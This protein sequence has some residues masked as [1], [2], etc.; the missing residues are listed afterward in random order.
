VRCTLDWDFVSY[1]RCSDSPEE[2][3]SVPRISEIIFIS[4]S[5]F[6]IDCEEVGCTSYGPTKNNRDSN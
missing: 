1:E 3:V 6:E 4:I 5:R 2:T